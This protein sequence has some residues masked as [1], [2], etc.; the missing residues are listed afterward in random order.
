MVAANNGLLDIIRFLLLII[1]KLT[2]ALLQKDKIIEQLHAEIMELNVKLNRTQRVFAPKNEKS[3]SESAAES[4]TSS[5][6]K[7]K[8]GAQPGRKPRKRNIPKDLK[9]EKV[10]VDFDEVPQ[11]PICATPYKRL[12][13]L[14]KISHQVTV[15]FETIHQIISRLTYKK[16]CNCKGA[17]KI[18]TAPQRPS[19]IKKSLLTTAMWIHLIIM[20]YHLAV[21]VYRYREAMKSSGFVLSPGTVENGFKKI[22]KLL[23]PV[24]QAMIEQLGKSYN[25]GADESRWKVFERLLGKNSFLWWIWVF[26]SDN[27][28]LYLIDPT[29][30]AS[31]M[32]RVNVL[33]MNVD[34]DDRKRIITADRYSAYEAM[35][36]RGILIAYCWVHL[37]R[38][39]LN[40]KKDKKI[41][42]HPEVGKWVDDWLLA[43]QKIFHLNKQRLKTSSAHSS[44]QE[45]QEEFLRLTA[46]LRSIT[47]ELHQQDIDSVPFDFQKKILKSFKKRFDGY[48]LF[49]DNPDIPLHNNRS[50]RL[51]KLAINGRKNYLGNVSSASVEH[52]QIFLS[53]IATAKNN[54][55]DPKLW[56][57]EYLEACARNDS[58]PLEGD[59]LKYY[60][61]KL[62]NISS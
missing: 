55:V 41:M 18:V 52:T 40:L 37:R 20:K 33:N 19:V 50:E 59:E 38:D 7:R 58:R 26:S 49:I 12:V 15:V 39:F 22:G 1:C 6:K 30:S 10:E 57:E 34:N 3:S 25:W 54:K 9:I 29:R 23:L 47:E 62:M 43:I 16:A 35:K 24:F 13:G 60:T 61:N 28:V 11:C 42:Q 4:N 51:L 53:I 31:V 46:Q 32:D 2:I 36:S 17:K 48:T 8:R 21:P 44:S 45:S 5:L 56:L 27:V 14:D